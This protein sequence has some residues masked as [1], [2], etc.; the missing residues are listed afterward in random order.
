M[1]LLEVLSKSASDASDL[2]PMRL[3]DRHV[4]RGWLPQLRTSEVTIG[5]EDIGHNLAG[6]SSADSAS[7]LSSLQS[8]ELSSWQNCLSFKLEASE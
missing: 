4:M 3:N 8:C 1:S 5:D 2:W 7:D 6:F